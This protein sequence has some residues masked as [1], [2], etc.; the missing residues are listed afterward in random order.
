MNVPSENEINDVLNQCI[1]IEDECGSKWPGMSYEQ[2]VR[3]AIEWMQ[4]N[5]PNP[6]ED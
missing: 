5:G 1:D 6:L 4:G 2:G 3:A